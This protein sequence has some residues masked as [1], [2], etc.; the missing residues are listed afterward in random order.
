MSTP[1]ADHEAFL[2]RY[3]RRLD[4][5]DAPLGERA[6]RYVVS[7]EDEAVLDALSRS[8]DAARLLDL[9]LLRRDSM[10]PDAVIESHHCELRGLGGERLYR[11]SRLW[12]AAL[13]RPPHIESDT[14]PLW[15]EALLN[16]VSSGSPWRIGREMG[17]GFEELESALEHGGRDPSELVRLALTLTSHSWTLYH[18]DDFQAA[19]IRHADVVREIFA[20]NPKTREFALGQLETAKVELTP[21]LDLLV[22]QACSGSEKV[23]ALARKLLS[24]V[25]ESAWP[26]IIAKLRAGGSGERRQAAKLLRLFGGERSVEPLREA[27]ASES[28]E[29]VREEISRILDTV[30]VSRAPVRSAGV[31]GAGL[32]A[33]ELPR[34]FASE[35]DALCEWY[36]EKRSAMERAQIHGRPLPDLPSATRAQVIDA[37][38]DPGLWKDRKSLPYLPLGQLAFFAGTLRPLRPFLRQPGL[39]ILHAYRFLDLSG[40]VPKDMYHLS[41]HEL[42]N[43]VRWHRSKSSPPYGLLDLAE[44]MAASATD[45]NLIAAMTL[46][47]IWRDPPFL[48]SPPEALWPY[49]ERY[50]EIL[51]AALEIVPEHRHYRQEPSAV[52]K[53]RHFALRVLSSFP[54]PLPRLEDFLW[55][56]ALSGSKVDGALAR[57][58]LRNHTE[59][60]AR[61][62]AAL[63]EGK[64][65]TRAASAEWLGQ[66]GDPAAA[67]PLAEA[68]AVETKDEPRS[69]M[70]EALRRLGQPLETVLEGR[71]LEEIA[72]TELPMSPKELAWLDG[73]SLP[74][75]H[76]SDGTGLGERVLFYL[77]FSAQRTKAAAPSAL[78]RAYAELLDRE[79][80][81]ALGTFLL[82]AWIEEDTRAPEAKPTSSA[83]GAKGVLGLVAA[84]GGD[85][86]A[87]TVEAYVK[88]WYGWRA[89]QCKALLEMLSWVD[90]PEAVHLLMSIGQRFRTAGIRKEAER[91]THLLA[92]RKEWTAFELGDRSI[93]TAGLGASGEIVLG[94][95]NAAR[96]RLGLD[97]ELHWVEGSTIAK[98]DENTLAKANKE[99]RKLVTTEKGRL[100]RAMCCEQLW[101]FEDWDQFLRRHP[102][103]G[104]LVERLVWTSPETGMSFRPSESRLLDVNGAAIELSSDARLRIGHSCHLSREEESAWEAKLADLGLPLLFEQ[105]GRLPVQLSEADRGDTSWEELEGHL[106]P[107][108]KL[109]SAAKR[110]GWSWGEGDSGWFYEHRK[111]FPEIQIDAVIGFSGAP[112]AAPADVVALTEL[113][114][115]RCEKVRRG[116]DQY[117]MVLPLNEVPG[118]LLA[119]CR[120]DMAALA[121]LGTG[122][123]P[124]WERITRS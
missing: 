84:C 106:V 117:A 10:P 78:L 79:D 92:E 113:R 69:A 98:K 14:L 90:T 45:P 86:I 100:Y 72:R 97:L 103:V 9:K 20:G 115:E 34:G 109:R 121:A 11:L 40:F 50:P 42:D 61:L 81:R 124:N 119:E 31:S 62:R 65:S 55:K 116:E 88:R 99:V 107:D 37:M 94:S 35:L 36:L 43:L 23:R 71:K 91:Q 67:G 56:T 8:P 46:H 104:K 52:G 18:A 16:E 110:L 118:V 122:F 73:S 17:V 1:S 105:F 26:Q 64:Q 114:F 19:L 108:R 83:M 3:L 33:S 41:G 54:K 89:P 53:R 4:G 75:V 70:M 68:L 60:S 27:L 49:Y 15:L 22:G 57:T 21:W 51:L 13:Q 12:E 112:I 95:G 28:V 66:S 102:V 38:R 120:H 101:R 39:G 44:A 96:A 74:R 123:D 25:K 6:L 59:R 7:G 2:K 30:D 63:K 93:P 29:S 111:H 5:L 32:F 76:W 58:C 48:W 85:E 47:T 24:P 82:R 77:V 87:E 80:A